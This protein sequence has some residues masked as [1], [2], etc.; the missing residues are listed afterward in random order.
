M[1]TF[2]TFNY[3]K[4]TT[5]SLDEYINST[6]ERKR[7]I[8]LQGIDTTM[9]IYTKLSNLL[10]KLDLDKVTTEN[11]GLVQRFLGSAKLS[12]EYN[13]LRDVFA[14]KKDYSKQMDP[15]VLRKVFLI[16]NSISLQR[17]AST[18]HT[19]YERAKIFYWTFYNES[20]IFNSTFGKG[21]GL[22]WGDEFHTAW[23]SGDGTDK[24]DFMSKTGVGYEVKKITQDGESNVIGYLRTKNLHNSSY[25]IGVTGYGKNRCFILVD[26]RSNNSTSWQIINTN[27]N[28]G[29]SYEEQGVPIIGK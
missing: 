3:P 10:S 12:V 23:F 17:G 1:D 13:F 19:W 2:F 14:F 6:N 26:V 16:A 24:P 20:T 25:V 18:I 8:L 11:V 9:P 15:C 4:K 22:E 21:L 7:E 27:L 28:L 5:Y 29:Q